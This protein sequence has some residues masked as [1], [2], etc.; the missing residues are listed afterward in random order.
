MF[1]FYALMFL[2]LHE[3]YATL[4]QQDGEFNTMTTVDG[5]GPQGPENPEDDTSQP[6]SILLWYHQLLEGRILYPEPSHQTIS[7]TDDETSVNNFLRKV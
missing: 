5:Y 6:L 4:P 3:S 7:F 2:N 1:M